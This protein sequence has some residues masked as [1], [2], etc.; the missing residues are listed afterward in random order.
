MP[1]LDRGVTSRTIWQIGNIMPPSF[2]VS[3]GL[4]T[5]WIGGRW[6]MASLHE[7]PYER[8]QTVLS[9][10]FLP[11]HGGPV[12]LFVDD[13]E[14]SSLLKDA[15]EP[16]VDLAE[17]VRGVRSTNPAVGFFAKVAADCRAW[18][19]GDQA[20]PPPVLPVLAI[21]VLAA[22]RMQSDGYARSTNY[23]LRLAETLAPAATPVELTELRNELS[24]ESFLDVVYMWSALH[25]W[26]V[27]Q[28]GRVGISTIRTDERRLTRI[29][30]P[31]SK[32]CSSAATAQN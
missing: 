9:A 26:I 12:V 23:Y 20:Q 6:A 13:A 30:Y 4:D 29:G 22:T 10:R 16:A 14:L 2:V 31:L 3:G 18:K 11:E 28:N 19:V 8:W 25:D 24:S 21:S 17:A 27:A 7:A 32:R 15:A 5:V 1:R